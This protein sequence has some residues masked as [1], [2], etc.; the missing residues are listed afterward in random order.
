MTHIDKTLAAIPGDTEPDLQRTDPTAVLEI[1][2]WYWVLPEPQDPE[3]P[4]QLDD[5]P[6]GDELDADIV[7]D[8][9]VNQSEKGERFLCMDPDADLGDHG[10]I[11]DQTAG[12][13][14]AQDG[15]DQHPVPQ[16]PVTGAW[17]GCVMHLGSNYVSLQQ[18][19]DQRSYHSARIHFKDVSRDLVF[20][21][22]AAQIIQNYSRHYQHQSNRTLK[23]IQDLT[24]ALGLSQMSMVT[25]K[26]MGSSPNIDSRT[27]QALTVLGAT[28][29]IENYKTAL[30][31]AKE[32][33]LPE[34][35]EVLK[36]NSRE[37]GRWLKAESTA[38]EAKV[39]QFKDSIEL[40][41][42]RIFNVSLYA[43]LCETVTQVREGRPAD[44]GEKLRIMQR[45]AYMDEECLLDYQAGGM[46]FKDIQAFDAWIS[47]EDNLKR[48][49][50]F[51]RCLVAMRVRRDVK[52]RDWGGSIRQL[53]I[54]MEIEAGDKATFLYIRNGQQ[55]WRLD[56]ELDFDSMIFPDKAM[57]NLSEPMM[58]RTWGGYKVEEMCTVA[59]YEQR[60][61]KVE[62]SRRLEAQWAKDN[63]DEHEFHNPHRHAAY[64]WREKEWHPFDESSLYF[65]DAK[66]MI[67]KRVTYYNRI[68]L[69]VQGLYDRS[70]A[71]HPHPPVRT[72]DP[73]GFDAAVELIYDAS[74]SLTFGEPPDFEAY[75]AKINASICA[76]SI[77]VGQDDYW[78]RREAK[79]EN[80]RRD[81]DYRM[82]S[83]HRPSHVRPWGN[84][85]PGVLAMPSNVQYRAR[86]VTFTWL[87]ERQGARGYREA[88]IVTSLT[89]PW[90]SVF[91]VSGYKRGDYKQF[92]QDPR[93]RAQYL[94]WA[95]LL[96]A[97]EDYVAGASRVKVNNP[98]IE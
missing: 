53:M 61:A 80:A 18:P 19:S 85:G 86:K 98:H 66:A 33:Q 75:R 41:E 55:L 93:T 27:T 46:E 73:A 59:D 71:L 74:Y 97:A 8:E 95:P 56:T 38:M 45:R 16:P 51:E 43:G 44:A 5:D 3:G 91:N 7:G 14:G 28:N 70:M 9:G 29:N 13:K 76:T 30:I 6:D 84:P 20:E 47:K 69:I 36:D 50:P 24:L 92:F 77:L 63:P 62:E 4:D 65:D 15:D 40:V 54:N 89:V 52:E 10:A 26:G 90:S 88:P 37:L 67:T 68:A 82:R 21:P 23:K 32:K 1:G 2:Q 72:W 11:L 17:L 57:L 48:I 34:L 83:E 49:L 81:G 94:K 87:R 12:E 78:A 31:L 39:E 60:L 35:F 25:A 58:F 64:D 42:D 22:R 96:M 79:K